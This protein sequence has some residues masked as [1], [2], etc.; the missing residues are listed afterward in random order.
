MK[1]HLFSRRVL[2]LAAILMVASGCGGSRLAP[3]AP[4]AIASNN[5]P[6]IPYLRRGH[7]A[8]NVIYASD[9]LNGVVLIYNQKGKHQS[10]IGQIGAGIDTPEGMAV[11]AQRNLYVV[12]TSNDTVTVYAFGKRNPIRTLT[13]A[14]SPESI[15]VG[16]DGTIYVGE[17]CSACT[18]KVVV[19][20]PG[21][22]TPS[23]FIDDSK[24]GQTTGVALDRDNNLYVGFTDNEGVGRIA[25]YPP[26]SHGPGTELNL[27][28]AWT[29][30]LAFDAQGRLV[31]VDTGNRVVDVFKHK[32]KSPYWVRTAQFTTA[33]NPWYC[34]FD[35]LQQRLYVNESRYGNEV[36]VYT[37]PAGKLIDTIRG[38][39]GGDLL[40]VAASP[41]TP[42]S[43]QGKQPREL[44]YA[45]DYTNGVVD[46][47]DTAGTHQK[48][49][50]RI[51]HG[52]PSDPIA[53]LGMA[54]DRDGDLYVT[55]TYIPGAWIYAR[56]QS[57]SYRA[58]LDEPDPADLV[59]DR[60]LTA[61]V[62]NTNFVNQGPG[63]I[64]VY[65]NGKSLPSYYIDDPKFKYLYGVALDQDEQQLYVSYSDV[66]GRARVGKYPV[67]GGAG[68]D[69]GLPTRWS[70]FG[71]AIDAKGSLVAANFYGSEIDV[72]PKG[73][74]R[75]SQRFGHP[76][77]PWYIVFNHAKNRLFVADYSK[78]N[79]IDE[80]SYPA[81]V[82]VNTIEG[83]PGGE[84]VGVT[85]GLSK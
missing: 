43:P 7:L 68:T 44:L 29:H 24:I 75:P 66:D 3:Q 46:V 14:D 64:V 49:L 73:A 45:S 57:S 40:A 4:A 38:I 15:A 59:V 37:Y 42:P 65:P 82:L 10:P 79:E 9:Y 30:G 70:Y 47:Y 74:H 19:Y 54:T 48:P 1:P 55:T 33:G 61:Y 5:G 39:P 18:N 56:G 21:A 23:Y 85:T 22:T 72:F 71:I 26:G 52:R 12:N 81:G 16:S 62:A 28:F 50:R 32:K 83:D 36:D 17:W 6:A 84:F 41:V 11:D 2:G 76:G 31:V 35:P 78:R 80:Y 27:G 8:A 58:L 20:L 53:P 69:L 51:T 63:R 60:H 77:R 25:E 34:A 67:A 13:Q